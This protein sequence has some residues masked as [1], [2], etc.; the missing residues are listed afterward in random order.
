MNL[1]HNRLKEL[2]LEELADL[3]EQSA[4][5]KLRKQVGAP[6]GWKVPDSLK[7]QLEPGAP[8]FDS[9]G[10]TVTSLSPAKTDKPPAAPRPALKP[11]QSTVIVGAGGTSPGDPGYRR[12][13]TATSRGNRTEQD[14]EEES[15]MKLSQNKLK[16]LVQEELAGLLEQLPA[17]AATPTG[18]TPTDPKSK[19]PTPPTPPPPPGGTAGALAGTGAGM[20]ALSNVAT[21]TGAAAD[22]QA[23][24]GAKALANVPEVSDEAA[25]KY[26]GPLI[27]KES[28]MKL[29]RNDLK[30]LV[31]EEVGVLLEQPPG[32]GVDT[33]GVQQS[34][35]VTQVL[36]IIDGMRED[37]INALMTAMKSAGLP[38]AI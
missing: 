13:V 38:I 5:E 22:V 20:K 18:T 21:A 30:Q 6:E 16:Q 36:R 26:K 19:V 25:A 34:H 3:L 10:V 35:K 24:Q 17:A 29:T 14:L 9:S 31:Q 28:T 4:Y 15:T 33:S 12:R 23:A 27:N 37:E 7:S 32:G 8:S 2:V 11:G 1:D